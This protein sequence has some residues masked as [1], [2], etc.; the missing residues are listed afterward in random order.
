M[1]KSKLAYIV[2]S[3]SPTLFFTLAYLHNRR[4]MPN[5]KRPKDLSEI[6]IRKVLDGDNMRNYELADKYLVRDFVQ[7]KGY[8]YTLPTLL[9]VYEDPKQIDFSRLP[10]KFAIKMNYG[11]RMNIIVTDKN[12]LNK[13]ETIKLL[14]KWLTQKAN[15][16]NSE[17]HYNKIQ[18]KIIIEEFIDDGNGGFPIDYKFMCINGRVNCIL[19]VSGREDGKGKYLPFSPSWEPKY[20]YTKGRQSVPDSSSLKKPKN[21]ADMIAIAERLA[22][23]MDLVRIDLYSNQEKIWFG[24]IT[25]T[26][27]GCIFHNWTQKA[28][29]DMGEEYRSK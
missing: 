13:Q 18:R 24:E 4:K 15:Y 25:L 12:K 22:E 8:G 29:D 16:S 26:P 2:S 21:L 11:A 23:G 17:R 28:L 19:A 1:L 9:G 14:N 3:I 20:E 6:W 5:F 7:N 10:E 27:S